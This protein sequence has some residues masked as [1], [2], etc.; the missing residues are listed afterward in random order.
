MDILYRQNYPFIVNLKNM[1]FLEN[2]IGLVLYT[3]VKIDAKLDY[4]FTRVLLEMDHTSLSIYKKLCNLDRD[5]KQAA[6][7]LLTQK[8]PLVGYFIKGQRHTFSTLKSSNVISL[9]QCKVVSSPLHVLE[10]QCLESIPIYYQ[11]KLQ[12]ADQVTRKT[13]HWSIKAPC[14]SENLDK[15][16]LPNADEDD[17]YRLTP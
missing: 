8:F 11:N 6:I 3:H 7:I 2:N 15:K 12:F 13:F 16:I 17:T 10:N 14:K 5:L 9:L 1:D 4:M